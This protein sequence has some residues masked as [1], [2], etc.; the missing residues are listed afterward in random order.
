MFQRDENT[1]SKFAFTRF[2]P[3][4][5]LGETPH[6]VIHETQ[7]LN[8]TS[9]TLPLAQPLTRLTDVNEL[10]FLILLRTVVYTF[11]ER[12]LTEMEWETNRSLV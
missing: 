3:I 12:V 6:R 4:T 11:A 10:N 1:L 7:C 9:A 8:C 2:W 5:V